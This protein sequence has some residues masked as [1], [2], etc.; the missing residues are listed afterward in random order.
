MY[1]YT[2]IYTYIYIY[3]YVC[4]YICVCICNKILLRHCLHKQRSLKESRAKN[5]T[6][7][8]HPQVYCS[9]S[10]ILHVR[11]TYTTCTWYIYYTYIAYIC[12]TCSMYLYYIYM[13]FFG[14]FSRGC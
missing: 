9:H 11:D 5:T 10:Y 12:S 7:L 3:I 2:Y 14:L 13:C 6:F 4:V 1:T 8:I